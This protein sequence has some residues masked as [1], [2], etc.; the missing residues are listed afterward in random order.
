M[1][2][3]M[4]MLLAT[5]LCVGALTACGEK[6]PENE[7]L[8]VGTNAEFP[9]FEYVG[10]DGQPD[11]FDMDLIKAIGE[12]IGVEVQIENMEF[13]ALVGAIGTKID[14]AI[15]GI[16]V[17]EERAAVVDFS[18][19]YFEAV[20]SVIVPADSDI[21]TI[22]DLENKAIGC[23]LGTTG[24]YKADE[25]EGASV[26]AY[27]KG[28]DAVN[29]L[30]NGRLDAVIIDTNPAEV[31]VEKNEGKL[32]AIDGTEFDFQPEYYAIAMPKGN[33]DLQAKVNK[34]LADLKADG[35]V[36]KLIAEYG[37]M[38]E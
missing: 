34:A 20:Q 14:V 31:F 27:N 37:L 26:Q 10:D 36:D 38:A 2:K 17:D 32:I 13:D 24:N 9:P 12:K 11:G 4:A 25:I 28:I 8:V 30:L 7:V 29:D 22:A 15:A 1:K 21:K 3:L 6:A 23:Q 35:T 19:T 33:A 5:V 16:T 18:D